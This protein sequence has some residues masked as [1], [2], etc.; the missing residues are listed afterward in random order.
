L[1]VNGNDLYSGTGTLI[2]QIDG[3]MSEQ[4]WPLSEA[5]Y[6]EQSKRGYLEMKKKHDLDFI[7]P[8]LMMGIEGMIYAEYSDEE[9]LNH[10]QQILKE[11]YRQKHRKAL[12]AELKEEMKPSRTLGAVVDALAK[13][14]KKRVVSIRKKAKARKFRSLGKRGGI[15]SN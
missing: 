11:D 8:F 13:D 1:R 5:G 2:G 10:F 3:F 4:S 9:M 12:L 7:D 15:G 14:A 6:P